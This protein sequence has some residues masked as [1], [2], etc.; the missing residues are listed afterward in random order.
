[1]RAV[2]LF[3]GAGGLTHG[4]EN[5][6]ISVQLGVDIDP[7]C[8]Y[9]YT[10]NNKAAFLLRSVEDLAADDLLRAFGH[11]EYRLL[12][13][14]APCQPFST[15]NQKADPSDG[16]W[17]LLLHFLRLIRDIL[18]ELVTMENVPRLAEQAVFGEFVSD[19]QSAGYVVSYGPVSCSDYGVPQQRRRLVLLASRLGPIRL[20]TPAEYGARIA[21]VR[22]AIGR[23]PRLGVRPTIGPT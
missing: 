18:P 12:A 11:C 6:G 19:L 7:A 4:L 20:L 16:R 21:T 13:G 10:G 2:D 14:C 1:M 15:Y 5:A 23:M 3:C 9:P 17:W 8:E 22:K